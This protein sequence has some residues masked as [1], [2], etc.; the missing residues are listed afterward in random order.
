[1]KLFPNF[2]HHRLITHT[3]QQVGQRVPSISFGCETTRPRS[4]LISDAYVT[5]LG[6]LGQKPSSFEM[7]VYITAFASV[8]SNRNRGSFDS[9]ELLWK[10]LFRLESHVFEY[11]EFGS[12]CR[13]F[14]FLWLKP[15]CF[16]EHLKHAIPGTLKLFGTLYNLETLWKPLRN[17]SNTLW[18]PDL[19]CRGG[20]GCSPSLRSLSTYWQMRD[21]TAS[22]NFFSFLFF[23]FSEMLFYYMVRYRFIYS[24]G[25]IKR[26]NA[27]ELLQS[28]LSKI[29]DI[30]ECER[31]W[32]IVYM[33]D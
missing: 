24:C 32:V 21:S 1:M 30:C 33:R 17:G 2:T 10:I 27:C 29:S 7:L 13:L 19:K 20:G 11:E 4:R 23:S 26:Y 6:S 12:K 15:I 28:L 22:D 5:S 14:K 8:S 18:K 9:D 25:K 31:Q 3:Y 16:S